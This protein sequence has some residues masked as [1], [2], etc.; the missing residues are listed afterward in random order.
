MM[1]K[2]FITLVLVQIIHLDLSAQNVADSTMEKVKMERS[3]YESLGKSYLPDSSI[4]VTETAISGVKAFWFNQSR[5]S[6]K[7]IIIYLHGGVYVLGSINTYRAMVSHL[8]KALNSPILYVE[9]SL[10]PEHPFP[11]ANDEILK[12]YSE[13]KKKYPG[14]TFTI[15]G[16][17][18]GGG[19]AITLVYNCIESK[20]ELPN[21]LALISPWINLKCDN[22][23]YVTKQL[24]DPILSKDF[25]YSHAL[26]YAPNKIKDADPSEL[27][28][29]TFPPVFLLVGTDEVLND[30][31]RN[32][33]AYIKPVQEKSRFKEYKDQK[34]VWPVSAIHSKESQEAMKD[35]K[36]FLQLK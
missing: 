17:S 5:L 3:F 11:A 33:Y 15:I 29:K 6:Q 32:F 4:S 25:L 26:L 24:L 7:H 10:A 34:H 31:S 28:F 13:L 20:I 12:V 22:S 23:S 21:S 18:A 16:D 30:D 1:S 2:L 19:L 9:Y 35:V 8:A 14:Y 27:K 36:E